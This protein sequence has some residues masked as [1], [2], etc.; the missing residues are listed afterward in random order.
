MLQLMYRIQIMGLSIVFVWIPGHIG[1]RGNETADKC[2]KEATERNNI[3]IPAPYSKEEMKSI[4]KHKIKNSEKKRKQ[5][6]TIKNN[7]KLIR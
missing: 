3:D 1:T 7:E 2:A 4:V 6:S 5:D